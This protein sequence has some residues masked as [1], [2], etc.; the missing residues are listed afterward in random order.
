[1]NRAARRAAMPAI[2][3][4]MRLPWTPWEWRD[5]ALLHQLAPR[6]LRRACLNNVYSVQF[7]AQG[8]VDHLM[9]RRHDGAPVRGWHAMQR[10]KTELCGADRVAVE[11]YPREA[12]LRDSANLY[13]LWVLPAGAELPFGLHLPS[14]D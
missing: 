5:D 8:D 2:K 6:G 7:Y 4:G 1:M 10:I 11:V 3:A 12:D 14:D 9:V 13:H